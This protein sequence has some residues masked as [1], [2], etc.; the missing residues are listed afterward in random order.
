MCAF[1]ASLVHVSR[2]SS[3]GVLA[4]NAPE[5]VVI[6]MVLAFVEDRHMWELN[7]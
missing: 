1:A 2:G 4:P 6:M 7:G 3:C 5:N